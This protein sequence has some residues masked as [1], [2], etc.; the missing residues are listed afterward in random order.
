MA[1]SK[2]QGQNNGPLIFL[3]PRSK[4]SEGEKV[5]PYFEVAKVIDGKI[6]K[7]DETATNVQG[8][9]I[10]I[11]FKEREFKGTV[12]KHVVLYLRDNS[13]NE[14]YS[15]DLTYK[16]P[17]RSLFNSIINLKTFENLSISYYESNKGFET[18]YLRQN[19]ERVNWKYKLEEQPAPTSVTFKGKQMNDYT[20]LDQFFGKELVEIAQ[21]LSGKVTSEKPVESNKQ[22]ENKKIENLD[23]DVPF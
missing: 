7:T 4:N 8:N 19:D 1:L 13:A 9:L 14:T 5:S 6:Q 16:L 17:T 21:K 10:K 11:E 3:N 22:V 2:G 12:N 18:F 15:L 20:E 23:E